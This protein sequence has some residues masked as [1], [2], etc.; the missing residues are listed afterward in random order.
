M[1]N[2]C[3]YIS[4]VLKFDAYSSQVYVMRESYL[5]DI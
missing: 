4:A 3:K 2:Y 5:L 1:Q